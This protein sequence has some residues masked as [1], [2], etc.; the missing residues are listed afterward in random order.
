MENLNRQFCHRRTHCED[1]DCPCGFKISV[2]VSLLAR[3]TLEQGAGIETSPLSSVPHWK[4]CTWSCS[5]TGT[6]SILS[7]RRHMLDLGCL[8]HLLEHQ[9]L[10]RYPHARLQQDQA[11]E[12]ANRKR[13]THCPAEVFLRNFFRLLYCLDG[14]YLVLPHSHTDDQIDVLDQ[15]TSKVFCN[16]LCRPRDTWKEVGLY[17]LLEMVRCVSLTPEE[18]FGSTVCS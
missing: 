14:S 18:C 3:R 8:F 16:L 13:T 10:T 4:V 17:L 9:P 15:R 2:A 11:T 1:L 5:T 6:S 12:S 7:V